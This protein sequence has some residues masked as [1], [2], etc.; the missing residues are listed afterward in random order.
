MSLNGHWKTAQYYNCIILITDLS[1]GD[2]YYA[3]SSLVS[4]VVVNGLI[5]LCPKW[6]R[7]SFYYLLASGILVVGLAK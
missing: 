6:Y 5:M 2:I 4:I 7:V 3:R 1:V